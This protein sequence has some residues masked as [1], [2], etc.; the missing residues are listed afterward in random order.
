MSRKRILC[1]IDREETVVYGTIRYER[2]PTTDESI[3]VITDEDYPESPA[4]IMI[5]AVLEVTD[6]PNDEKPIPGC[7]SNSERGY[8]GDESWG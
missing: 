7:C 3:A 8:D 4:R 1:I 6:A 2:S 5:D